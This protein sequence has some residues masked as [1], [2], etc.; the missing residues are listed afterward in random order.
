MC[1]ASQ[2]L[3]DRC[4]ALIFSNLLTGGRRCSSRISGVNLHQSPSEK[5][6]LLIPLA[7]VFPIDRLSSVYSPLSQFLLSNTYKM[8]V[9]PLKPMLNRARKVQVILQ[10]SNNR[11][12]VLRSQL[13]QSPFLQQSTKGNR[14]AVM[15]A[16]NPRQRQAG[17]YESSRPD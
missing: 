13:R 15:H 7:E 11:I 6:S 14:A 10:R 17:L 4:A 16:F 8:D 5:S 9:S 12:L 3:P 2:S 1:R